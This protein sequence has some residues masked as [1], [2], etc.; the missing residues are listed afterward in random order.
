[1]IICNK[2]DIAVVPFPFVDSR[3][4]KPRPALVLSD[5]KFNAGNN[6]AVLAMITTGTAIGW[7]ND[8]KISQLKGT[9][10]DVASVVRLKIFTLD[11][12]LIK[13]IIG[14][15]SSKDRTAVTTAFKSVML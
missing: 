9:G 8:I 12:R 10:L 2:W 4:A 5:R 15:L 14:T 3:K 7:V 11:S 13:K 6:H 1:M